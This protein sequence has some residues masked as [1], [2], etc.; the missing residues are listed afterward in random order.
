MYNSNDDRTDINMIKYLVNLEY[1][2]SEFNGY[3]TQPNRNT[4]QDNIEMV[5]HKVFQKE[6]KTFGASRTDARVHARDQYLTF[7][8]EKEIAPE[9]LKR[10]LN[11]QTKSAIN[12][13][14]VKIVP[15]DFN[16]RYQVKSKEYH[17]QIM[18]KYDPFLRKY[19]YYHPQQ[20]DVTLMQEATKYII[21]THD[22]TSFC[23]V[24][25]EVEDKV[26]TVFNLEVEQENNLIT[27]KIE[28]NGFLYNMVRII[29]GV[30]I[31]IGMHKFNPEK[32]K[33]LIALKD[34]KQTGKTMPPEGL[35]LIKTNY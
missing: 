5:L 21:G 28:G 6:I 25:S 1:D 8:V 29:V 35:F 3:A 24:K 10:A 7:E 15:M 32:I 9:G 27:I 13:K 33:E 26:R 22:F 30:L 16:P 23:N 34:R 2:G 18:T 4:I 12:I 17:Y 20:L 14:E 19:A 11:A 31:D